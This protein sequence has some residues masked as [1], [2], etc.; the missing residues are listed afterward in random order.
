[1]SSG[2][3]FVYC[4]GVD[5]VTRHVVASVQCGRYSDGT[6]PLDAADKIIILGRCS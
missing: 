1:M 5:A 2:I 4:D 3:L 6:V